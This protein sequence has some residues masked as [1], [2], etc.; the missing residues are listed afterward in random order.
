[1]TIL[2]SIL[3]TGNLF[4]GFFALIAAINGDPLRAAVA[5]LMAM[6]FDILD[7]RVARLTGTTSRF[8]VEYDSLCDLV[9]F[10]V[11]P[12]ILVFT[13]A[14]KPYGRYGWLA[15]FIYVATT[16]LRLARFNIQSFSDRTYFSGLPSPAAAGVMASMVLFTRWLG[17]EPPVKHVT[18]LVLVYCV[19]YLMVSGIPYFSFKKIHFAEKHP[20]YSLVGFVL[21][22]TVVA[23]EPPLTLFVLFGLYA[24]SGPL[25]LGLRAWRGQRVP[26]SSEL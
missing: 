18:I 8:G 7:G 12:A 14:L 13:Y 19:S 21:I 1:M 22:L 25:L 20:F 24:L 26:V 2:P 10:G 9:S 15:A 11:A 3:T 5:I 16:A 4:C 6:I 17:L 23:A